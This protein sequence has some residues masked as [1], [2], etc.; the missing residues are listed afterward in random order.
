M[1]CQ[2]S[3]LTN[4]VSEANP[5]ATKPEEASAVAPE[6][7]AATFEAQP[8][9]Q[10]M[11]PVIDAP[12]SAESAVSHVAKTI[13]QTVEAVVDP[14]KP[15][16]PVVSQTATVDSVNPTAD[17]A[18]RRANTKYEDAT[19]GSVIASAAQSNDPYYSADS[20]EPN[21]EP[22]AAGQGTKPEE[23]KPKKQNARPKKKKNKTK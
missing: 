10:N 18:V 7:S 19:E 1:G 3:K 16:D 22:I 13:Q 9:Q 5:V 12:K 4:P 17:T 2:C 8:I 6:I 21:E 15:A 11:E 23:A 14:P 20:E